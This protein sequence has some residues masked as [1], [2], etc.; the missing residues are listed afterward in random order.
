MSGSKEFDSA[1]AVAFYRLD[2]LGIVQAL[3]RFGD[4]NAPRKQP[5]GAIAVGAGLGAEWS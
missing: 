1:I 4:R 3:I 2:A 5:R